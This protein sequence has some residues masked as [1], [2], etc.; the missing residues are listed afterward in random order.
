ML[1]LENYG[2][3]EAASNK[4]RIVDFAIVICID[5]FNQILD[6]SQTHV[7]L[8]LLESSF[9]FFGGYEAIMIGINLFEDVSQLLDI[10]AGNLRNNIGNCKL[11]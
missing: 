8:L 10:F 3:F 9:K 7:I 2:I 5:V 11:F 6:F 4:L 1:F